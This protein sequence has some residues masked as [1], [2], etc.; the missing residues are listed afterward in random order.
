MRATHSPLLSHTLICLANLKNLAVGR[1][2]ISNTWALACH[3][4]RAY[5][6]ESQGGAGVIQILIRMMN[7]RLFAISLLDIEGSGIL[8]DTEKVVVCGVENH[9]Q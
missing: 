8:T 7:N 9:G 2:R 4:M 5:F 1:L 3:G 6:L